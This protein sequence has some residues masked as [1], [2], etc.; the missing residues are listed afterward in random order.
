MSEIIDFVPVNGADGAL[1]LMVRVDGSVIG[2]ILRDGPSG[3]Y[4]YQRFFT[5]E[6]ELVHE[7]KD[8]ESL[9]RRVARRP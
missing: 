9:L 3:V 4:C 2:Q 5:E 1:V 7:E 8:L 6:E